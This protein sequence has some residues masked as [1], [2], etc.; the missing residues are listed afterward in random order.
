MYVEQ[1]LALLTRSPGVTPESVQQFRKMMLHTDRPNKPSYI[2]N[3]MPNKDR[4]LRDRMSVSNTETGFLAGC[5]GG[6]A[7]TV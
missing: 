2:D 7:A 3:T 1:F 4:H 6:A 5:P